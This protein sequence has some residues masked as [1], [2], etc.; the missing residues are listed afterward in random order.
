MKAPIVI[1]PKMLEDVKRHPR[2][3]R[4]I[5]EGA[6]VVRV[7]QRI[8]FSAPD[9][10]PLKWSAELDPERWEVEPQ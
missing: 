9:R 8:Y 4:L 6:I 10:E 5:E 1:A 3:L 7:P 2:L